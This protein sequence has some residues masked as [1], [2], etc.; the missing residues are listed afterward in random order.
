M[1]RETPLHLGHLRTMVALAEMGAIIVPPVPAFYQ[2]PET[3]MDIVDH[4]VDRV[5][6]LLGLPAPGAKRWDGRLRLGAAGEHSMT[7]P[8]PRV[9]FQEA[10]AFSGWLSA[11][12]GPD[13]ELAPN[14]QTFIE[15]VPRAGERRVERL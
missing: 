8:I 13:V 10:R 15:S 4:T 2:M 12:A 3:I 6:D 14:Y 9:A 5:L 11:S 1:V 7:K